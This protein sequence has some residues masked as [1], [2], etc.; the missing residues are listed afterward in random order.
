MARIGFADHLFLRMHHGIG[1]PVFNQF[2]WRFERAIPDSELEKLHFNLSKGLLSRQVIAPV[3]PTARRRWIASNASLPLDLSPAVV[4]E[5]TLRCWAEQRVTD[6]LDPERGTG[7][8][9][10]AAPS[11]EGGTVVS[12]V[13]SH[14]I[15]DGAAMIE[16][17]RQ[18]NRGLPAV[19]AAD[20]GARPPVISALRQDIGDTITQV[21]PIAS[22]A[23]R[24]ARDSTPWIGR[25]APGTA[26]SAVAPR[27][28]VP[29]ENTDPWRP[30]YVVVECPAAQWHA[31]ATRWGGTSTSLFLGVMTALTER[32]GRASF[33]DELRWSV[34]VSD[35]RSDDLDANSTKIVHVSVA[36]PEPEDR[37]LTRIRKATKTALTELADRESG[38]SVP[39]ELVQMLPDRLV[40]KLPTPP[41]GAEGLCSNLGRLPHDFRTFGGIAADSISARAIFDGAEKA[42]ARSLGGGSTAWACESADT[43]TITVHGMDPDRVGTDDE[44]SGTLAE[45]LRR[46]GLTYRFW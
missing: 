32:L 38:A 20:L 25:R 40:A 26:S 2:V 5:D 22:W 14:M 8:Q 31:A 24:T 13:C 23:V 36:V 7:W 34:P 30:P 33:G 12:L 1:V 18:A 39:L 9:L 45:V 27:R 28:R 16:A 11:S 29:T 21:R 44:L 6:R 3:L 46:W 41:D 43:V 15:A 19:A 10:A 42:F 17:V 35:R 37:D 4:S